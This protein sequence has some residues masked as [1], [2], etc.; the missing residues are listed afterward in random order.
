[1]KKNNNLIH[2]EFKNGQN[3][4]F[5][6]IAAIFSVFDAETIGISQ[7]S[8]YCYKLDDNKP[9]SNKICTIRRAEVRRKPIKSK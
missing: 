7:H 5:G 3:H 6:S 8:L 9:Y 1:M 2:L 4:Y